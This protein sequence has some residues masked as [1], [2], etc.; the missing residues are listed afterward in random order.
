MADMK[1]YDILVYGATGFTGKRVAKE[2][3]RVQPKLNRP[4]RWA[5]AGRD[6]EKLKEMVEW[7]NV[8]SSISAPAILIADVS[9]PEKLKKVISMCRVVVNCVGPFR[10]YG[11]PVVRACVEGNA[12]YVDITGEPEFVER[13]FLEF[14][15]TAKAKNLAVVPC[16]G[17]DSVP[18]DLGNLFNKQEFHKRGYTASAVEM[19]ISI[20]TGKAGGAGNFATYESAVHGVAN[21]EEL[22]KIRKQIK[23]PTVPQFG[24][25]LRILPGA[26]FDKFIKKWVIPFIGADASVVR[27]GQQLSESLRTSTIT[28]RPVHSLHPVQFA[29]Y[30]GLKSSLSLVGISVFGAFLTFF[31]VFR[32]GRYLLLKFPGFFSFGFFTRK[33]PTE[34]QMR[35]TSFTSTFRGVGY[36]SVVAAGEAQGVIV[37]KPEYEIVTKVD[38]PEPGYVATPIA[39]LACAYTILEDREKSSQRDVPSGVLTPAS[40][41][42]ATDLV[43]KLDSL[44]IKFSVVSTR[45]LNYN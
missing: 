29:A 23:R 22:R 13:V 15:E 4:F 34:A 44:G 36:K 25:K 26:R 18:A 14:N 7:L 17:F 21:A 39:V 8:P 20:F 30:M 42:G 3:T 2:I 37:G 24:A 9:E 28:A 43:P 40:A 32:L 5:V 41:F 11:M 38:G 6:R 45:D 27:M 16:C 31:L 33:G 19:Y 12:E 10:F 1:E 35:D